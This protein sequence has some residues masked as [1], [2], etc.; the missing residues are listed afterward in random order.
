MSPFHFDSKH[1]I[2]QSIVCN[3]FFLNDYQSA[4][5]FF[6]HSYIEELPSNSNSQHINFQPGIMSLRWRNINP[7]NIYDHSSMSYL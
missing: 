3:N 7:L 6:T 2:T 1:F 5:L 4:H